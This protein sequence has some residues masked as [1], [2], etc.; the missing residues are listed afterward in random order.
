MCSKGIKLLVVACNTMSAVGLDEV[1]NHCDVSVVGV[2]EPGAR[3]A[4]RATKAGRVGIIGTEATILS[5]AYVKAIKNVDESIDIFGT[6]CPLF[7]PLC[8]EGWTEGDVPRLAAEKYLKAHK[9]EA[10]DAL[11]LGC[12]HYPLLKS[13]I[14]EI[15]GEGVSIIDSASETAREVRDVLNEMGLARQSEASTSISTAGDVSYFVTDSVDKFREVGDR[16]L[17]GKIENIKKI[18]EPVLMAIAVKI[19][20]TRLIDNMIINP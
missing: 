10:I 14:A 7:V 12:T 11:V 4:V 20:D 8:E 2:I 19:G 9:A 13:V 15:M 17:H 5:A 16:F 3:A 6:A 1:K 18:E